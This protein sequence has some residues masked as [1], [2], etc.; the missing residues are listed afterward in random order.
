MT[1]IPGITR[2]PSQRGTGWL[3]R[4]YAAERVHTKLFSDGR[5][6]GDPARSQA[7]ARRWLAE[8]SRCVEPVPRFRRTPVRRTR[9]GVVGITLYEKVERNG[10]AFWV[11]AVSYT[12]QGRRHTKAFRVHRYPSQADAFQAALAFR[13]AQEQAMQRERRARL[14]QQWEVGPKEDPRP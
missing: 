13:Q 11:Y 9:T 12:H 4:F 10:A 5:Y 3:A 7:A 2:Y 8:L 6:G 1:P 14:R